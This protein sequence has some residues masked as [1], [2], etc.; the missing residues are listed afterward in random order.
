MTRSHLIIAGFALLS[1]SSLANIGLSRKVISLESTIQY[2]KNE[3]RLQINASVPPLV[4]KGLDG[5]PATLVYNDTR[6]P[7]MLYVF[8]PSCVWCARNRANFDAVRNAAA[9]R[10][11]IVGVSTVKA[12]LSDYV[13]KEH[14]SFPVLTD[15]SAESNSK[16]MFG[17]T[18]QTII[19]S[20]A[21]RVLHT[22]I[23]AYNGTLR[24]DIE[25]LMAIRLPGLLDLPHPPVAP[26]KR[27]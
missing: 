19:I 23:G 10:Y 2:L 24:D 15:I 14:L 16:Y 1:V 21:G 4:G 20:P 26:A 7:T 9:G 12:G 27:S 18:P 13:A 6:L 3:H 8:S 17:G 5:K 11:R 22:W 25:K